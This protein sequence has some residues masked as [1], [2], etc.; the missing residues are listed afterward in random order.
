M[1]KPRRL[2]TSAPTRREIERGQF[3]V[4]VEVSVADRDFAE[5]AADD[6]TR[7]LQAVFERDGVTRVEVQK[8]VTNW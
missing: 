8:V 5:H 3:T 4:I 1:K 7:L 6:V 2:T